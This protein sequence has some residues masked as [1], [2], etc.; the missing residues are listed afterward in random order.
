LDEHGLQKVPLYCF[1]KYGRD[2]FIKNSEFSLE[3][4]D[5]YKMHFDL[6]IEDSP[7]AF[8]F[9]EHLPDLR[10]MVF[11]RPWN[12]ECEFPNENYTRCFNWEEI[13]IKR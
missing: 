13:S 7:K 6:A 12:Q 2:S 10:V 4:E 9:F 11:D 5:Y 3:L 8:K 1:N